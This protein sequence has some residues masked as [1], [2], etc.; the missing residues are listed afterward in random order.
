MTETRRDIKLKSRGNKAKHMIT[1][2]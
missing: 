1:K 2:R